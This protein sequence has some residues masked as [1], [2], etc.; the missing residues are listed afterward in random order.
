M[1]FNVR[2]GAPAQWIEQK[3]P[4]TLPRDT[5]SH[6]IDLNADRVPQFPFEPLFRALQVMK[7]EFS[8]ENIDLVTNR[9]SLRKLFD[10]ITGRGRDSYRIDLHM[11]AETLFL[12]RRERNTREF[13]HSS[14]DTGFGHNFEHAFSTPEPGIEESAGHH[15][16]IRYALGDLNCVVRFEVDACLPKM[17]E[18][19]PECEILLPSPSSGDDMSGP[20]EQLSLNEDKKTGTADKTKDTPTLVVQRGRLVHSS[21][22]AELKSRSKGSQVHKALPQL[23]FGRTPHLI[24]GLHKNGTFDKIDKI[25]VSKQY[26]DWETK[27]QESLRKMVNLITSLRRMTMEQKGG[28]CVVVYNN[29]VKPPSLQV[30]ASSVNNQVLPRAIISQYWT[31]RL[32]L[33]LAKRL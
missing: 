16:V 25:D 1:Q 21:T 13:I 31:E 18:Q 20:F 12:T 3:L 8:L 14:R 4:I 32:P 11:V 10:F 22:M 28:R 24:C 33:A 26:Q 27:Y 30:F 29:K 23:W 5:G 7:P 19:D 6:F 9:N 17:E 15:R 2:E